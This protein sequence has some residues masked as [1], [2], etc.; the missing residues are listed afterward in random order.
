MSCSRTQHSD[1][2]EAKTRNPSVKNS[3][4]HS[5]TEPLRS[6]LFAE[7]KNN[8]DADQLASWRSQLI[9]ISIVFRK[10][11]QILQENFYLFLLS[12]LLITFAN[13]LDSGQEQH[14]WK[15]HVAAHLLTIQR[16][17]LCFC[18]Y[19]KS[20]LKR[21]LKNRQNKD[22]NDKWYCLMK[23][24]SIAEC[25]HWSI[26]QFFWPALRDNRSKKTFFVF[27]S[28]PLRQILMYT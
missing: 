23:G 22:L 12:H 6:P 13:S 19:N 10:G 17:S 4:K 28:G 9:C 11:Y 14:N 24:E 18:I 7:G 2:G 20:C 16:Q 1:A 26:L 21:P 3:V 5:T 27:L 25:S 15:S 8:A